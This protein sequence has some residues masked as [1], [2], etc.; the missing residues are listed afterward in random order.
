MVVPKAPP[1][2]EIFDARREKQSKVLETLQQGVEGIMTSEGYQAYLKTMSKFHRYSFMNSLLIHVQNP[3]ATHVAGYRKW[4]ELGRQVR[5]GEK[6]IKIYVPY[7]RKEE[8]PDTGE[9]KWKVKGFG[10]GNVF[11]ISS[12]DGEPLPEPPG[13]FL[14][15]GNESS[16]VS[17]ELNKRL[18]W[19]GVEEGLLMESRH[20]SGQARGYY[21]PHLKQIVIKRDLVIDED[22][23]EHYIVDPLCTSKT[24][25][26]TH[27][28]GHYV[29]GHDGTWNRQ[30][31]EVI[32]ESAAFV[33]LDHFGLDTSNYSF[34]YVTNWA[35]DMERV[36]KNVNE[37]QRIANVLIS[38]AEG[39]IPLNADA[40]L[41]TETANSTADC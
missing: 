36:R 14:S 28:L 11:D 7:K 15:D 13:L 30:D 2:P 41:S 16:D 22:G 37:V 9:E 19:W 21:N 26:L 33:T 27:E 8:D 38:A 17:A 1:P 6:A 20:I 12:T 40:E 29:G 10:V 18:G 34:G 31:A 35:G 5:K 24:K 39:T 3:D 25:T 23:T 4:Q 32:A